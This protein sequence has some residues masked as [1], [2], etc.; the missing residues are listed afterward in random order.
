MADKHEQGAGATVAAPIEADITLTEGP[1]AV[2]ARFKLRDNTLT[3]LLPRGEDGALAGLYRLNLDKHDALVGALANL[4]TSVVGPPAVMG[5]AA[6]SIAIRAHGK[7]RHLTATLPTSDP[8]ID[9][10]F[11][12]LGR[13]EKA[14]KD[15][16]VLAIFLA[17]EPM[18]SAK[19]GAPQT[20]TVRIATTGEH[21]AEVSFNPALLRLQAAAEPQ[22]APAGVTPLPPEWDQVSA[23]LVGAAP[24]TLKA[25]AMSEVKLTVNAA[26]PEH[27]WLRA[28]YDGNATFRAPNQPDE[29]RL[30]L[31]SKAVKFSAAPKG[32]KK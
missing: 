32:S 6:A 14:A 25:G 23:P 7:E 4:P 9:K 3:I 16:P 28:A 13:C 8:H 19:P 20:V 5:M 31:T 18:V 11:V 21:G 27:R 29:V 30:A 2:G 12:E 10:L 26:E 17:V 22:P 15:K 24:Q 1:G